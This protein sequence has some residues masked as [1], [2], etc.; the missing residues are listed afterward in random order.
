MSKES[1]LGRKHNLNKKKWESKEQRLWINVNA[2]REI[3]IKQLRNVYSFQP[4]LANQEKEIPFWAI[5]VSIFN[6]NV[7]TLESLGYVYDSKSESFKFMR[8]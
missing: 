3:F 5:P 2:K 1:T 6:K 7:R 4:N 8:P